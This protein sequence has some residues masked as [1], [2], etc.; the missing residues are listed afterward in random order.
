MR[1]LDNLLRNNREWAARQKREKPDYFE[2]LQY[3]QNPEYFWIGC[4]D[5]RVPSNEIVGLQPGELFV[6]RNV[7]NL[8]VP[9]DL[10]CVSAI[11]YAVSDLHV[12]HIIVCGHYGCGGVRAALDGLDM[13]L[14]D[15]WLMHVRDAYEAHFEELEGITSYAEKFRRLC[16]VN[17]LEQV[18]HVSRLPVVEKA[19]KA[20][21]DL[22]VHGWIYSIQDGLIHDLH[23][24]ASGQSEATGIRSLNRSRFR[25][26]RD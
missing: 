2:K 4:S 19:W 15:N 13:G 1:S 11:H 10:N 5:S 21:K 22:T 3:Q 9:S 12:K 16:E 18:R 14:A 6:H 24:K 26:R 20:R 25:S 7:A 8:V 17:V 23:L